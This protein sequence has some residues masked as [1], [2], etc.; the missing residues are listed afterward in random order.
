MSISRRR[1]LSSFLKGAGCFAVTAT[2]PTVPAVLARATDAHDPGAG[3]RDARDSD[4]PERYRFPQ[5]LASGDPLPD[6]VMLW[7]RVEQVD[8]A[9][10]ASPIPLTVQVSRDE[11]FSTVLL[12][13]S[14]V[15]PPES[16]GTVRV[17]VENLDPGTTYYY[18][19]AALDGSTPAHVGRTRTAPA[20]DAD[21]SV[22]FAVASCQAYEAGHF[23]A[24]R[25]LLEEQE[26]SA[27]PRLD[28]VLHLGDFIYEALG[29]G[30]ARTV[31]DF[32][33]GGTHG[34]DGTG[35]H[36]RTLADYRHLYKV[37]LSDPD[38]QEA[39]ARFPFINIWDDHEF[40]ND[41]WQSASTY[42]GGSEPA[43]Q[44]KIAANRA[45]FEFIPAVLSDHP[46]SAGQS[47]HARD[48][49][50]ATVENADFEQTT[51][52]GLHPE[53]NNR[54]AVQ[55]MTIYRSFRWGRHM[56]L[57]LTDT[58]SY[59]SMH[60]VPPE[61]NR[62]IAGTDRYL[63]P[64]RVVEVFDAGRTYNGG[65]PPPMVKVGEQEVPNVRRD[66][67]PG[68][69]LGAPQKDWWKATMAASD[70]TWKIWGHSVPTLPM[71]LDLGAV[72][73]EAE[74]VVFTTDTWDGYLTERRE[75]MDFLHDRQ[76]TN[77]VSLS[78]DNHNSFAG[79][80]S[81]TYDDPDG[82]LLENNAVGAEFS[83]C[84][85]SSPSVFQALVQAVDADSPLRPLV[86]HDARATGG[87]KQEETLNLT[88]LHG[89]RSAA[90]VAQTG[91]LDQAMSA[92]NDA[93][94]PHLRYVDSN[95]YGLAIVTVA[96]TGV[97]AEFVTMPPPVDVP[98]TGA[99][100]P[101][102]R[103]HFHVP[104]WT[105]GDVPDLEGPTITGRPPF[106]LPEQ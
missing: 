35:R 74:T 94:N 67:P 91:D 68:T 97:D 12:E 79:V 2:V 77:I 3:E 9:T 78:G 106:P 80:L 87:A 40:T 41:A 93:P 28:A 86:T 85:I 8:E 20:P 98:R 89:A 56:E 36:A 48:F 18:R 84:G 19:F 39:R 51:R 72:N 11:A 58:R 105:A 103:T 13:Q 92:T 45:W 54:T 25:W 71:R 43:Q 96:E 95:A 100:A 24:Y 14:V 65:H 70:A 26:N 22:R 44:R 60:P 81:R 21:V 29:Y 30:A 52:S 33:D 50:N 90:N 17:F 57:T 6:A 49:T 61:I 7:T 104:T 4:A 15:A 10:S 16:D 99:P 88:F 82:A 59:R 32:P 55:S 66:H 75:L 101:L 31:P 62:Q 63:T 34:E 53:S 73:P 5:G 76:I 83:V 42:D 102:R 37:Y 64:L 38:L 1:F 46:G 23:G 47:S 27:D 69:M